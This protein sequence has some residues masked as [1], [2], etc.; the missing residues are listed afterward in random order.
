MKN[1]LLKLSGSMHDCKYN[2]EDN[3][4]AFP[5]FLMLPPELRL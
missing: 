4:Q 1:A 3:S 5:N 2:T